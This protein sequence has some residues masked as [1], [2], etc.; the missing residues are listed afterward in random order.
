MAP[1]AS[2]SLHAKSCDIPLANS[3]SATMGPTIRP[4]PCIAKT[5]ETSSPRAFVPA[6]SDMMVALTG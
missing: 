2:M 4:S 6:N 3:V 1:N 5:I